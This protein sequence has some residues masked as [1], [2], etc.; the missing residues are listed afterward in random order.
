MQFLM[1]HTAKHRLQI[2]MKN[3]GFQSFIDKGIP[4]MLHRVDEKI[5]VIDDV[6]DPFILRP[7]LVRTRCELCPV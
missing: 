5:E 1:N 7:L 6:L 2:V 4:E 3:I